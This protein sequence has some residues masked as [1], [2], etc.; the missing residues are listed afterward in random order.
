MKFT[1][2]I[3]ALSAVSSLCSALR[4]DFDLVDFPLKWSA[5]RRNF[6]RIAAQAYSGTACARQ[7]T[8]RT[9]WGSINYPKPGQEW[10]QETLLSNY[11]QFFTLMGGSDFQV[12]MA[13]AIHALFSVAMG[14]RIYSSEEANVEALSRFKTTSEEGLSMQRWRAAW[15]Q[16]GR[17]IRSTAK[18]LPDAGRVKS[19]LGVSAIDVL[20]D[21]LPQALMIPVAA[22]ANG[23]IRLEEGVYAFE[24]VSVGFVTHLEAAVTMGEVAMTS[25]FTQVQKAVWHKEAATQVPCI[26]NFCDTHRARAILWALNGNDLPEDQRPTVQS[27][28]DGP[29]IVEIGVHVGETS[30]RLMEGKKDLRWLGIDMWGDDSACGRGPCRR[31]DQRLLEARARMKP[32]LE[33]RAQMLV[34]YSHDAT[35]ASAVNTIDAVFVDGDHSFEGAFRDIAAWAPHV[36]RGGLVMGHDYCRSFRGVVRAV[37]KLIPPKATLHLAA[38][39]VFWWRVP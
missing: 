27:D 4:E 9:A 13:K 5:K 16:F 31:G 21:Q 11:T 25:G 24:E 17:D 2:Y 32:W 38:D 23:G 7:R 29:L 1:L 8:S 26:T 30:Q 35:V 28:G 34:G 3:F 36:R 12:D 39:C 15:C 37:N 10:K 22:L 20:I 33:T 18:L 14:I 6:V 19:A